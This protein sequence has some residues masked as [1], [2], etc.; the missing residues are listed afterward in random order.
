M[1][2]IKIFLIIIFFS[3]HTYSS[4][5]FEIK[6]LNLDFIFQNSKEGKKIISNINNEKKKLIE[7]N[8]KKEAKLKEKKD[9][10]LSK[11]NVLGS[12]EFETLV[13]QHQKN[14]EK[15]QSETNNSANKINKKFLEMNRELKK[16]IDKILV[17]YV[18]KNNIDIILKK[19]AL[20]VS[21]SKLDITK[22]ILVII[23]KN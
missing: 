14:V 15:Y 6:Y 1:K 13:I 3:S 18:S 23:D 17:D 22:E 12:E 21:N 8:K 4:E 16:K 9:D 5:N 7:N 10:I 19:D 11:K 20:I 2:F